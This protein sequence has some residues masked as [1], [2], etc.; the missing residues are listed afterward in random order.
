MGKNCFLFCNL[1]ALTQNFAAS[2]N[3]FPEAV[4]VLM[5]QGAAYVEL[6]LIRR[7]EIQGLKKKESGTNSQMAQRVLRTI[8]S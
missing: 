5:R 8:G 3:L 2:G 1:L 4:F 6:L 7:M